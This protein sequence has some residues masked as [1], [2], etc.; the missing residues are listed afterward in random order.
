MTRYWNKEKSIAITVSFVRLDIFRVW[1]WNFF[2]FF[3]LLLL[4]L[5]LRMVHLDFDGLF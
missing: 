1:R 5:L 2:L 3:F 4:L